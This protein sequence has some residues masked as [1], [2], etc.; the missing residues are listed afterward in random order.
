VFTVAKRAAGGGGRLLASLLA[1][2]LFAGTLAGQTT[3]D[4]LSCHADHEF[5]A[6]AGFFDVPE[7]LFSVHANVECLDCHTDL[8]GSDLP[9]E[10]DLEPV[11]CVPCHAEQVWQHDSSIHGQVAREGRE[12]PSCVSCHGTHGILSPSDPTSPTSP[13]KVAMLCSQ[14]HESGRPTGPIHG[15]VVAEMLESFSQR[16][17]GS[18]LAAGLTVTASCTSCHT[19][20][21]ILPATDRF[22]TVHP[23]NVMGTCTTCHAGYSGIHSE[24]IAERL[25]TEAP[26]TIP[27]CVDCHEPHEERGVAHWSGTANRDCLDCHA[28]TD[29]TGSQGGELVSMFVDEGAHHGSVHAEVACAQCHVQ[30]DPLL[31]RPCEAVVSAV[32]C[33]VCHAA[34]VE[35]YHL[36]AH[37]Q[38]FAQGDPDAP[39]CVD[40]HGVH[41]VLPNS[42]PDSPTFAINVPELCGQCHVDGGVAERRRDEHGKTLGGDDPGQFVMST[43]GKA[44]TERGLV[45]TATCTSCHAAHEVLEAEDPR[46]QVSDERIAETCG[47][48]HMGIEAT[49][50]QSI[51]G[52]A[53]SASGERLPSCKDCHHSHAVAPIG[54]ASFRSRALEQCASCHAEQAD[55]FFETLH[56]K[57]AQ[58]GTLNAARCSDCHGS[59][60]VHPSTDPASMLSTGNIV[61]TCAQCHPKAHPQFTD[62]L[63]HATHND[64]DKYPVLFWTFWA[65]T[66]LVVV[67]MTGAFIHTI[68]FLVRLLLDRK[69]WIGHKRAARNIQPGQK[70]Y[71]RFDRNTRV[72]HLLLVISFLTLSLTGM[73]LKFSYTPWALALSNALG[74]FETTGT[75]HRLAALLLIGV[76]IV[77]CQSALRR[78][79]ERKQSWLGVVTAPDSILFNLRDLTEFKATMRWFFGR[80]KH[81]R[82]GRYTY[83]EKFDYFAV[84]WGVFIIGLSGLILWF[85]EMATMVLPG[86]SINLAMIVHSDEALLA[87]AF[88]FTVHFFNANFRPDKFPMDMAMFTGRMTLEELKYERPAEYDWMVETGQLEER[89]VDPFPEAAERGFKLFASLA[90]LVGVSLVVLIAYGLLTA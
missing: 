38:L 45:V 86:G 17:H 79:R 77:H 53:P 28:A 33:S 55:T 71:R 84:F 73:M 51:H 88:I 32:D 85:P 25:W 12:S 9:H 43:H 52:Q 37:G 89:L 41:D 3:A 50:R 26:E 42:D 80:G 10:F 72:I 76:F 47:T 56:G 14:C 49:F 36:G 46:S 34:D 65:M 90:L 44:L 8:V 48:C 75:L 40:C 54:E 59:H 74:G 78:K 23:D 16:I 70:L 60:D 31:D 39:S 68:L 35:A 1:C 21:E 63:T 87:V 57:V 83:W 29:L 61:Q 2:V 66:S 27:S 62:F 81:P 20:H 18:G 82:Y 64:P 30:V 19:A 11:S 5:V 24:I 22:S 15:P 7:Y 58:L 13:L 69:E 4:C 67:T 6:P